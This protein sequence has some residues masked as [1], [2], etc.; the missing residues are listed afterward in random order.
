MLGNFDNIPSI[1]HLTEG[2][3]YNLVEWDFASVPLVSH[4]PGTP[5]P[6]GYKMVFG[7]CRKLKTGTQE[8]DKEKETDEEKGV[9][10]AGA[11]SGSTF[12]TNK[13]ISAGGKKY[14][15]AKLGGKPV[16]V[17]WGSVAGV[18][19]PDGSISKP[20]SNSGG[21]TTNIATSAP[22]PAISPLRPPSK[23]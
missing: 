11:K 20:T 16:I 15:W 18:K 14:G 10:E 4:T 9:R 22:R 23:A 2:V 13:A 8:W 21:A 3:H 6:E 5:C 12:E 19:N 1:D 17:E 7:L